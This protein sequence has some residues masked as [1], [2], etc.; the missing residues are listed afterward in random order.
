M[1]IKKQEFYEGAA[2]YL[3]A[4]T[5]AIKAIHYQSP[6]FVLNEDVFV[7]LKYS[8][9]SRSPWSFTF[10][11]D[12]QEILSRQ[13]AESKTMIGLICGSDGVAACPYA[14]YRAVAAP[15]ESAIHIACYRRHGEH[16]EVCGP[17]GSVAGKIPPSHWLRIL[18]R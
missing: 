5:G 13:A 16:Y 8:T 7:L 10:T 11:N 18:E 4:R 3:L 1:A 2:I 9:K 12:E 17:D 6:F 14:A 15:R